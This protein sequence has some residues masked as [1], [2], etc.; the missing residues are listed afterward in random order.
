M[1]ALSSLHLATVLL[2]A[3]ILLYGNTLVNGLFFDDQQFIY[4]NAAVTTFDLKGLFSHSLIDGDGR[5]TNYY[6]PFLFLGFSIEYHLFGE[7]GAIYHLNSLLLHAGAGIAIYYLILRLSKNKFV[8]FSTALLFIVHP[9]QTEAVA[10]ASGRGDPLSLF[11]VLLTILLSFEKGRWQKITSIICL[12]LALLSKETALITPGL[13]FISHLA[14]KK[15]LNVKS[16]KETFVEILP[17][18]IITS[19]Y[20]MLRLT[21]LNFANT[22][23]FY[24]ND[25]AYTSSLFVRINEFFNLVPQYL[26]LIFFPKDLYMERD[27]TI[28]LAKNVTLSSAASLVGSILTFLGAIKLY[29]NH[30]LPLFGVMWTIIGFIPSSGIIPI[31]GIFYEHFLYYPS[32]GIFVLLSYLIYI[33]FEK[34]PLF[35][36]AV[37][38]FIVVGF[39]GLLSFR[40]IVRNTD[41]KDAITFYSRTN[42]FVTSARIYNNLAMAYAQEN[43]PTSAIQTYKKSILI[44]NRYPQTHYNLANTYMRIGDIDQAVHEYKNALKIDP[45]FYLSYARLY[46][47]YKAQSDAK[48]IEEIELTLE[49]LGQKNPEFKTLLE[50]LKGSK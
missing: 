31:N 49:Q 39:I 50:T 48:G 1:R 26:K 30:P 27:L 37:L 9:V 29:K 45:Y 44:S 21:L 36:R 14:M 47:I 34:L 12:G 20:F 2:V 42:H 41:W 10:Y 18:T 4:E 13:L 6:R 15:S 3:T 19:G 8:S 32:I 40:T 43:L 24:K 17:Y 5:L 38:I 33:L 11:L 23:N 28:S 35:G 7:S 46:D 22:L 16:M 25:N